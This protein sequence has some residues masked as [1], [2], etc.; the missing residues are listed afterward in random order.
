MK[1]LF[2]YFSED[3]PYLILVVTTFIVSVLGYIYVQKLP[4]PE[5]LIEL[6]KYY[7][8]SPGDYIL[9]I[10]LFLI[11]SLAYAF[12]AASGIYNTYLNWDDLSAIGKTFSIMLTVIFFVLAFYFAGYFLLTVFVFIA[13]GVIAIFIIKAL[14]D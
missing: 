10:I 6:G 4:K 2:E 7:F 8:E 12:A 11:I 3:R 14:N 13:L 5:T 9:S 1:K